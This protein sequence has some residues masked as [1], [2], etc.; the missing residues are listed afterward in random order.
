MDCLDIQIQQRKI[1][2]INDSERKGVRKQLN[3]I[4]NQFQYLNIINNVGLWDI[5]S[6]PFILQI[7]SEV[8][9]IMANAALEEGNLKSRIL[10]FLHIEPETLK[11]DFY[12]SIIE[13]HKILQNFSFEVKQEEMK[14]RLT[15]KTQEAIT[16]N[17]IGPLIKKS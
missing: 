9:P 11:K 3:A 16:N 2:F 6:T 12:D 7:F 4:W 13:N 15:D 10:R 1:S 5:L 14:K 8:I 17:T